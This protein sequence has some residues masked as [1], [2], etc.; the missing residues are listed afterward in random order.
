MF[1]RPVEMVKLL[2]EAGWAVH[3]TNPEVDGRCLI[4]AASHYVNAEIVHLLIAAGADA[5]DVNKYGRAA[6]ILVWDT[7]SS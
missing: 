2:L 6:L 1:A 7:N 5:N 4:V 3:H